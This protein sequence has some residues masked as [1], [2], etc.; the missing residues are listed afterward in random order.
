MVSP[1]IPIC[2]LRLLYQSIRALQKAA[3]FRR[4]GIQSRAEK[5]RGEAD[6]R[7]E[8]WDSSL[9]PFPAAVPGHGALLPSWGHPGTAPCAPCAAGS[10]AGERSERSRG[11][12]GW[13]P[14]SACAW[15]R[16]PPEPR[17]LPGDVAVGFSFQRAVVRS[18]PHCPPPQAVVQR[19]TQARRVVVP[20]CP[21]LADPC[22]IG[23]P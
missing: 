8:P 23:P 16:H 18:V 2:L 1:R 4:C 13:S 6:E 15:L 19:E 10:G 14:S 22:T 11:E 7:A 20:W 17:A 12:E 21:V 9:L 3:R 5:H